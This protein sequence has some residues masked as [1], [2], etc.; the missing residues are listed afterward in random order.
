MNSWEEILENLTW[1]FVGDKFSGMEQ[2]EDSIRTG[3]KHMDVMAVLG[4]QVDCIWN[5]LKP[6]I[7]DMTGRGFLNC[8]FEARRPTLNVSHTLG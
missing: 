7:L 3:G 8:L 5:Q 2:V 6:K 1:N 4:Y